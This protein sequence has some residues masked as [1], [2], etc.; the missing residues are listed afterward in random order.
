MILTLIAAIDRQNGIGFKNT[1]PWMGKIPSDMRWFKQATIGHPVVMGRNTFD[2]MG[3]RA[4]PGRTN[5]VLTRQSEHAIE[6]VFTAKALEDVLDLY[7]E[8]DEEVFVIGGAQIYKEALPLAD[9]LFITV[10]DGVFE[11]D[12]YFPKW[13]DAEWVITEERYVPQSDSDKFALR[14]LTLKRKTA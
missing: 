10:V 11:S 6:R 8:T 3:G 14:F 5:Y 9:K 7:K 2:A 1:I 13:N 12:T 4:L